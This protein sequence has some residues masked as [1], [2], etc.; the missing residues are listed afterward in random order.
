MGDNAFPAFGIQHGE[1]A[2]IGQDPFEE[3]LLRRDSRL[4]VGFEELEEGGVFEGMPLD[5]V[6]AL[7]IDD[8][9]IPAFKLLPGENPFFLQAGGGDDAQQVSLPLSAGF[10]VPHGDPVAEGQGLLP[11]DGIGVGPGDADGGADIRNP[12]SVPEQVQPAVGNRVIIRVVR[13]RP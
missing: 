13:P 9:I 11:A 3:L 6:V 10:R 4:V 2:G 8:G 1:G 5:D 7:R 12:G